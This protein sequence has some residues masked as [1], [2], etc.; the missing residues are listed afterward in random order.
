MNVGKSK[1]ITSDEI[2]A[3]EGQDSVRWESSDASVA[4]VTEDG[5]IIGV[6]KG[7]ATVTVSLSDGQAFSLKVTVKVP[8][9]KLKLVSKDVTIPKSYQW[10]L[11]AKVTPSNSTDKVSYSSSNKKVATVSK[12]GLVKSKKKR[13]KTTITVKT[14]SGKKKKCIVRVY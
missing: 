2:P 8:A 14:S 10:K 5:Y 1:Q 13:G 7:T 11:T 3:L 4:S 6:N 12:K 9:K